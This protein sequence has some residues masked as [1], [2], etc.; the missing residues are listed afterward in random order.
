MKIYAIA[1]DG[2]AGSGKS[3]I[4]RQLAKQLNLMYVDTGAMYRTVG[5]YCI[6]NGVDTK[7][8]KAVVKILD[9]IDMKISNEN[10]GQIIYLNGEN[11]NTK[12]RTAEVGKKA[13][14]VAV[15]LEVR[16]KLVEIQRKIA[17]GNNIVM[18]G[19][20]IGTNVLP[21]ALVKIYLS[22]S[23]EERAKRRVHELE[24]FGEKPNIETIK[25]QIEERDYNDMSR[26]HNPL[27]KAEDAVEIESSHLTVQEVV[28]KIMDIV[29][30]KIGCQ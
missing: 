23:V 11:V 19:R 10:G 22:A 7:D 1:I 9:A 26:E 18:D 12:I 13:S 15:V 16:E 4:A 8:K 28:K 27:K 21:N 25:K 30:T 20:D 17:Q 5:L 3:T 2:P 6:E 29:S 14:D 24:V